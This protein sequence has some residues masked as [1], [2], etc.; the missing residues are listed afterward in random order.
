MFRKKT[1]RMAMIFSVNT[2]DPKVYP[3]TSNV[4]ITTPLP[5]S[6]PK[7]KRFTMLVNLNNTVQCGSCGK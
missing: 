3:H 6:L 1:S 2:S 7:S 4:S 5:S